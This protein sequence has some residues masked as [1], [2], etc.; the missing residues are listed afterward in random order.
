MQ[1]YQAH[2]QLALSLGDTND[3]ISNTTI[4]DGV[5]YSALLRNTYLYLGI[6]D[7]YNA[8]LNPL[9]ALPHKN[10]AMVVERA[11][12]N[13]LIE[14]NPVTAIGATTTTRIALAIKPLFIDSIVAN[15]TIGANTA[16][17]IPIPI[18][19]RNERMKIDNGY[20]SQRPEIY[21][22]YST[23]TVPTTLNSTP[24]LEITNNGPLI[25]T[26]NCLIT[27]LP[28]VTIPTATQFAALA[29]TTV[30]PLSDE[31]MG[32]ALAFATMRGFMDNQEINSPERFAQLFTTKPI[33]TQNANSSN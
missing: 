3:D 20:S 7:V 10:A 29:A 31:F 24:I 26:T 14:A 21:A 15:R 9:Y 2:Q 5:R 25:A 6:I 23:S 17:R 4:P 1:L 12:K 33:G 16:A 27:Y 18:I 28:E 30:L 8:I 32:Q 19:G 11:F 13:E 22:S